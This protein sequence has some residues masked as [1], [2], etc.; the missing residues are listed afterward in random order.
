M[1]TYLELATEIRLYLPGCPDFLLSKEIKN[2]A[3][4]FCEESRVFHETASIETSPGNSEYLLPTI[5]EAVLVSLK[6]AK[7]DGKT[8]T[9]VANDQLPEDGK[10]GKPTH[11]TERGKEIILY[12]TPIAVETIVFNYVLKPSRES[13]EIPDYLAEDYYSGITSY[14]LYRLATMPERTWTSPQLAAE[15]FATY[16]SQVADAR[17]KAQGQ[18]DK[19]R[20][21]KFSW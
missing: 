6:N 9:G 20:V 1:A 21:A 5:E 10:E 13:T 8:L 2:A 17:R 12:P 4:K 15:H 11:Y 3:I 18:V 7:V 19:V 14:A 16:R